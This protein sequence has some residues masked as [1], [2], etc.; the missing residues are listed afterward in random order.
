MPVIAADAAGIE[1]AARELIA[2]RLVA[3][4][5]ETVYGL[6]AD[7]AN[8]LAVASVYRTKGRPADHPLIVHVADVAQARGW[9]HWPARAQ[10]LADA[11]WP[12]P[13]T[14]ILPRLAHAPAFACAGQATIGL[15]CPAHPV[16]AALLAA[17]GR[18]GGRG[19]A[20]PSANRFGRISPTTAAHVVDDLGESALTVLDGGPCEVGVESTIVDLS[21]ERPVLLRPGGVDL[22]ALA[23]ALGEPVDVSANVVDPRVID[24]GAPR[25]SGTLASHYAPRT[26]LRIVG[27]TALAAELDVL[28]A[29]GERAALCASEPL[30]VHVAVA[31]ARVAPSDAAAYARALYATLRA[32]DAAGCDWLLVEAPPGGPAWQAVWDRLARAAAR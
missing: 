30:P 27:R 7:A 28:A 8:A 6:G 25:A 19:I 29:R 32:L 3:F 15:R 9:A 20:G 13:L 22:A 16:A 14:L 1:R 12:G 24:A 4:P 11:F 26:P 18:L 2:G 31:S 10:R 5:T 21:R 23:A 17:F